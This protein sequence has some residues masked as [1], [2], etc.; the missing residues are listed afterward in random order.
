MLICVAMGLAVLPSLSG[1]LGGQ[2]TVSWLFND[3]STGYQLPQETQ[4]ELKRF[5]STF[6]KYVKASESSS[7]EG[8]QNFEDAFKRVRVHYVKKVLDAKLIDAALK[9][10]EELKPEPNSVAPGDLV[11]AALDSMIASLDPHSSY[12]NGQEYR[13]MKSST[14][15]EFGGL[16]IQVSLENGVIKV[17]SPIED[18]PAFRAGLKPADLITHLNGEIIKDRPIMYSVRKMRGEPG[19]DITLT[20][21]REGMPSFDVT[22]TRAIIRV[23]SVKWRTEGNIG[24]IRVSN[25]SERVEVGV[26]DAI[27]GIR[28]KLGGLPAG[29]VLDLR[30]NP[31]GL[32]DQSIVLS[33]AFLEK[34]LIVSIKGRNERGK[35]VFEAERGDIAK[36]VPM[37]VLINGGS[38]SA[39]EIVAAALRDNGRATVMGSLSFGKGSVQTVTPLPVEGALRL[40]T[41]LYYAPSGK[42]IQ[43][44]GIKPDVAIVPAKEVKRPRE[45][46]LPG[47]LVGDKTIG[48]GTQASIKE[49]ACPAIGEKKDR[50]LGCA[51][52][53]LNAGSTASFLASLGAGAQM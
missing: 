25:F 38:A 18:T 50:G 52:A 53:L 37:V 15:G 41:S 31:G 45:S 35:R 5:S 36:G 14:R 16:G 23:K 8:L 1:C 47:A 51:L 32:L 46:D 29:I 7:S 22:I 20:I 13:E 28:Q 3:L 24:Y 17:V 42:T 39:S 21:S 4:D 30:N 40:T 2:S 11:E 27:K 49:T 43:S 34:G 44:R 26:Y 6:G 9:G 33:D 12:L 48:K 19:S 10:V